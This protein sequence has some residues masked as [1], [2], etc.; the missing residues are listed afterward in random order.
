MFQAPRQRVGRH[1]KIIFTVLVVVF[2]ATVVR[3]VVVGDKLHVGALIVEAIGVV[4]RC[5]EIGVYILC[6]VTPQQSI[7]LSV[8]I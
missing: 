4:K 7:S 5:V 6:A 3:A 2:S 1:S 8:G